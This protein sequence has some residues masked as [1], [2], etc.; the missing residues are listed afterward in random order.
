[1]RKLLTLLKVMATHPS[2]IYLFILPAFL[3]LRM[4]GEAMPVY[5]QIMHSDYQRIEFFLSAMIVFALMNIVLSGVTYLSKAW[6]SGFTEREN[7]IWMRSLALIFSVLFVVT[8]GFVVVPDSTTQ[9]YFMTG[10]HFFLFAFFSNF[11]VVEAKQF[12]H[13]FSAKSGSFALQISNQLISINANLLAIVAF[14]IFSLFL[15]NWGM[16]I[17]QHY[18]VIIGVGLV[19]YLGVVKKYY[20]V[21]LQLPTLGWGR[22]WRLL[23][24][25]TFALLVA[26]AIA[27]LFYCSAQVVMLCCVAMMVIYTAA[28]LTRFAIKDLLALWVSGLNYGIVLTALLS[29]LFVFLLPNAASIKIYS[30][31]IAIEPFMSLV[32]SMLVLYLIFKKII[33]SEGNSNYRY[34][35]QCTW[36]IIPFGLAFVGLY[37]YLPALLL[38]IAVAFLCYSLIESITRY[39][40]QQLII[41]KYSVHGAS[42]LYYYYGFIY[43]GIVPILFIGFVQF[44]RHLMPAAHPSEVF[45]QAFLVVMVIVALVSLIFNVVKPSRRMMQLGSS[46]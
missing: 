17:Y 6:I 32:V 30:W 20:R 15:N 14:F 46:I 42:T 44:L 24:L 36:L 9:L 28:L 33:V 43:E 34:I 18:V 1:M 2:L 7:L 19:F 5:Q 25:Y 12:K 21:F 45:Y 31:A 27:L 16:L 4:L 37:H 41:E 13:A 29:S 3:P 26:A 23:G 35:A 8:S 10:I 40:T 39:A 11:V 22:V 38:F